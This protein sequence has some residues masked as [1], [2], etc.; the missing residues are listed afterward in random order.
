ME[1]V[2]LGDGTMSEL[3]LD[4]PVHLVTYILMSREHPPEGDLALWP[5]PVGGVYTMCPQPVKAGAS[6]K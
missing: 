5:Q 4:H 3:G 2:S 1:L 6:K